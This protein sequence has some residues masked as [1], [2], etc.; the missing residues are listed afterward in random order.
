MMGGWQYS[1]LRHGEVVA[2]IAAAVLL[3]VLLALPWYG[4]GGRLGQTATE[5]GASTSLTGWQGLPTLRWLIVVTVLVALALTWSQGARRAPALP[6]SLSVIALVL[7]VLTAL[8]LIYRVL[9]SVPGPDSLG[10]AKAGAYV[11]LAVALA[12]LY[13]AFRSLREEDPPDPERN[14]SIP[15]I[16]LGRRS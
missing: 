12:L 10:E 11:G 13:G 5:L 8:G 16:E 1:R 2:G 3:V 6:A 14:A 9:I 4:A 7:S 15:V